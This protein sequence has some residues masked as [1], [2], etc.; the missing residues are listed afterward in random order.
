MS[1]NRGCKGNKSG[2]LSFQSICF[3]VIVDRNTTKNDEKW[4]DMLV[5]VFDTH[6]ILW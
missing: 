4:Y 2:P 1:P 6:G 5:A 3:I